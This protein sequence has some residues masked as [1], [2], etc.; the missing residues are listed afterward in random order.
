MFLFACLETTMT[1][2]ARRVNELQ[3]HLLQRTTTCLSQQR[4]HTVA[5]HSQECTPYTTAVS[6]PRDIDLIITGH[7]GFTIII[8]FILYYAK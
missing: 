3:F 4:L 1:E 5:R 8:R 2:L 6:V 7:P